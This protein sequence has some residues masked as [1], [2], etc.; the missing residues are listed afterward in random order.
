MNSLQRELLEAELDK[1]AKE[2]DLREESLI[3][4]ERIISGYSKGSLKTDI[5]TEE[6]RLNQLKNQRLKSRTDFQKEMDEYENQIVLK[7][8]ELATVKDNLRIANNKLNDLLLVSKQKQD[9]ANNKLSNTNIQITERWKYYKEQEAIITKTV[10]DGNEQ[11]LS[12]K[13][14]VQGI[15]N[16]KE[17]LLKQIFELTT[18]KT[19]LQVKHDLLENKLNSLQIKYDTRAG[20][21]RAS[22]MDI[23]V[24]LAEATKELNLVKRERDKIAKAMKLKEEELIAREDALRKSQADLATEKRRFNS[25]VSIYEN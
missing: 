6:Y 20:T 21:L 4:R 7:N 18:A 5:K 8:G 9:E 10:D 3:E 25:R 19:T 23:N 2:L 16:Q 22:L 12:L 24:Q 1:R 11:L 13:Y 14:E 17:P 15:E